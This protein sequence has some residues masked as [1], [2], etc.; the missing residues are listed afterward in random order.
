MATHTPGPWEIVPFA[1]TNVRQVG[2]DRGVAS[3]GG[4]ATTMRGDVAAENEA[5]ARL[6][7]AA[8]DLLAACKLALFQTDEPYA[9]HNVDN[10]RK[11]LEAAV[12]KAE[13]GT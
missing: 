7:A 11:L 6:I 8:P 3:C 10:A 13:G 4:Y 2:G 1:K 12:A 5:N 9:P